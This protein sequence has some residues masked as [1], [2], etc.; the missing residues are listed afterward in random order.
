MIEFRIL[1]SSQYSK[2]IDIDYDTSINKRREEK[3]YIDY[4]K[5]LYFILY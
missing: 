1:E 4:L 5:P 3:N 2:K